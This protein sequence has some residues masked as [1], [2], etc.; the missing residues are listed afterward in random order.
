MVGSQPLPVL[1][2]LPWL[3]LLRRMRALRLLVFFDIGMRVYG[4]PRALTRDDQC[5]RLLTTDS[6]VG[7]CLNLRSR[8]F[9]SASSGLARR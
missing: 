5:R 3:A 7:F 8:L 4:L 1:G 2:R 6:V 9:A